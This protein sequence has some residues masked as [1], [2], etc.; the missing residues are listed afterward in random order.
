MADVKA[1]MVTD[2]TDALKEVSEPVAGAEKLQ[3][4]FSARRAYDDE[5]VT[6]DVPEILDA[7]VSAGADLAD[8]LVALA[9]PREAFVEFATRAIRSPRSTSPGCRARNR[10][11]PCA[12]QR[13]SGSSR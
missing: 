12:R 10:P 5:H 6:P 2:L 8:P 7:L 4:K 11:A 1:E 3:S 9:L 13:S